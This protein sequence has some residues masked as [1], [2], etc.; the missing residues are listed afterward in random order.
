MG[1]NRPL[2]GIESLPIA[3]ANCRLTRQRRCSGGE[4]KSSLIHQKPASGLERPTGGFV[5]LLILLTP[6]ARGQDPVSTPPQDLP[7]V[8]RLIDGTQTRGHITR[9]T[10]E[11][12]MTSAGALAPARILQA[13]FARQ[14]RRPPELAVLSNR[15]RVAVRGSVAA[16]DTLIADS[17]VGRLRVPLEFVRFL[18]FGLPD[19][20]H[21]A[22][23]RLSRAW[24]A[25]PTT[26][27]VSLSNL[28]RVTGTFESL[29]TT[30]LDLRTSAASLNL[31]RDQVREIVFN[32]SLLSTPEKVPASAIVRFTDG[33]CITGRLA[34]N[35]TTL[36]TS[37][38]QKLAIAPETIVSIRF[39]PKAVVDL[40]G[41][42]PTASEHTPFIGG[43]QEAQ[44]DRSVLGVPL[45]H[46]GRVFDRGLG[47]QSRSRLRYTLKEKFAA[48]HTEFG[49]DDSATEGCADF[50]IQVDG[51]EIFRRDAVR[52]GRLHHTG[53][54]QLQDA[55]TLTL[56]VDYGP[57]GDIMDR[58]NWINPILLSPTTNE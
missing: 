48:F 5:L 8:F 47:V 26:D 44:A 21:D 12:I 1:V 13:D 32:T 10:A 52:P 50:I 4:P 40:S 42:P 14:A 33:S 54:I 6:P 34:A 11:R 16:D 46:S 2:P 3:G 15:D 41:R 56:I 29:T 25:H 28:D 19:R 24:G 20:M 51:Q 39:A 9:I 35:W 57:R 37:W 27:Q 22:E 43:R 18:A 49:L 38:G 17:A 7:V 55:Q 30:H 58:A 23:H 53:L 45:R 31:A 36:E